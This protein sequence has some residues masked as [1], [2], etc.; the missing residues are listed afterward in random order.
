MVDSELAGIKEMEKGPVPLAQAQK[1]LDEFLAKAPLWD[2]DANK[3]VKADVMKQI[4]S[5]YPRAKVFLIERGYAAADVE[6]MPAIQVVL[7]HSKAEM[8]R[9]RD[10]HE[11]WMALPF[12]EGR[13]GLKLAEVAL[14]S[15]RERQ[16]ALTMLLD[17]PR[18]AMK[19]YMAHM[20]IDRKL[21]ALR[22][23]EA[24]KLHVLD[25]GKLPASL[26]KIKAVPV[27]LDPV[28]NKPFEYQL[29]KETAVLTAPLYDLGNRQGWR[30][31]ITIRK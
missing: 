13:E 9:W 22:C 7:L 11:K 14:E 30:Y 25:T 24:I 5:L 19:I 20:R 31:E 2:S 17:L 8:E 4:L 15:A 28:T 27:P 16:E 29:Q 18:S 6:K 21:A 3:A 23:I 12:W 10:Q 1:A 26:D